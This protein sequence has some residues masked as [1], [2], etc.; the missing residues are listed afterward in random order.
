MSG[1]A[2]IPPNGNVGLR[3]NGV[4]ENGSAI[5]LTE[6]ITR[7]DR[8]LSAHE[9]NEAFG[10]F[11]FCELALA[12]QAPAARLIVVQN[13]MPK[14]K[15]RVA[16]KCGKTTDVISASDE[17]RIRVLVRERAK[18]SLGAKQNGANELT[19]PVL[20]DG[21]PTGLMM[22]KVS[23]SLSAAERQL[24]DHVA[25]R[26]GAILKSIEADV[27][28]QRLLRQ[29]ESL[30][31]ELQNQQVWLKHTND[32][33]E[34]KAR[35]LAVQ[36]I[37]METR[38]REIE[39]ARLA[40]Q[41]QAQQ[42]ALTSK[43]KSEF[44][45]NMSHEL[46]TPLNS[47]LLLARQLMDNREKTLTPKQL[48]FSK[49]IHSA[50]QELLQLVNDILDLAKIEAGKISIEIGEYTTADLPEFLERNFH[51]LAQSKNL[52]LK[53]ELPDTLP[54]TLQTD[55]RRL[56]QILKNL[57]SNALKFTKHGGVTL[58]AEEVESGWRPENNVLNSAPGVIA[59]SVTDT[60]IG[61]PPEKQK[62]IF[63]AFQQ[64]DGST[65]REYGGTGLGLTISR[66]LAALLG[67]E[68]HLQSEPG[69]GSTFTL[70]IPRTTI[71]P[72][73]QTHGLR[74]RLQRGRTIEQLAG[75]PHASESLRGR[76]ALVVDDDIRNIFALTSLLE[77]FEMK[78]V[79]AEE[80][81]AALDYLESNG[82]IDV[83]LMDI[84]MPG[85]DGF[86]VIQKLRHS[87]RFKLLPIIAVTA[88][89]MKGDREKCLRAGASEYVT[90]PIDPEL[91]LN[92]LK[93]I[94]Q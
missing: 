86:T 20:N 88:K 72:V 2:A 6:N 27:R 83:V 46:R 51:L 9:P 53:V 65:S 3:L 36:K 84:M 5:W 31:R 44:L 59:F 16:A 79:S 78:V 19:L 71:A 55:A 49:V 7:F 38:N 52:E 34:E 54:Q 50:G 90:K 77:R 43:Y 81:Q 73:P 30:T 62:L 57:L 63:E 42:L 25:G 11:I 14:P 91:L 64:A 22:F 32:E 80:G 85:M 69:N 12:V 58:R 33:L 94:L 15:L 10:Q 82:C 74:E 17:Q 66:E 37:E 56:E 4:V 41:E 68:I 28:T 48:E 18:T 35:M 8:M 21:V 70:Y 39:Q 67:G 89:A 93:K 76:S 26:F 40:L 47:M 87:E 13:E 92:A 61:I 29:S 23:H 60:G 1:C 45:A 24:L 75:D